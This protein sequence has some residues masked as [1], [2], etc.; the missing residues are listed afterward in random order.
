MSVRARLAVSVLTGI[1]LTLIVLASASDASSAARAGLVA[2]AVVAVVAAGVEVRHERMRRRLESSMKELESS[3]D[4]LRTSRDELRSS[5]T[6]LGD[7]VRSAHDV[8]GLLGVVLETATS[9]MK[10]RSGVVYQLSPN[11]T[12]LRVWCAHNLTRGFTGAKLRVGEGVAGRVALT[13]QPVLVPSSAPAPRPTPAELS[14]A[15]AIAVPIETTTQIVGVLALYGREI[16][17]PFGESDLETVAAVARHAAVGI[18]NVILHEDARRQSI[19]DGLTAVWNRRY[20]QMHLAQ[21]VERSIRFRRSLSVVM[22]DVDFFKSV[23]DRFGHQRGDA[24][25]VELAQRIVRA[26]RGQVDTVA[27]FGGE[28]FVLVLPETN[29]EGARIVCEKVRD[30]VAS[31]PFGADGGD[32]VRVTASL[33]CAT[34][35]QHGTTSQSLLRAADFAM[36]EAKAAGRNRV[37]MADELD[38]APAGS[39][40]MFPPA[41]ETPG[42]DLM[43]R[44]DVLAVEPP[45][46]AWPFTDEP[47]GDSGEALDDP[48][49]AEPPLPDASS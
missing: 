9:V 46:E 19:T 26:V 4:E 24:V 5:L 34:F 28:E 1:G 3:R 42:D 33:G 32:P 6:R 23:N 15:T 14:A 10:A 41:G 45:G 37:V 17:E 25:L 2:G 27:R 29:A 39:E 30:A 49:G 20:L 36:Y 47:F 13:R 44:E 35:P 7:A 12:D 48:A 21:E 40:P 11:R 43:F 16:D 22:L 18:D 38:S 8:K 31:E